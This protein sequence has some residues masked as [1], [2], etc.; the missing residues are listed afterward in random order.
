MRAGRERSLEREW[1]SEPR[2]RWG[3]EWMAET[4]SFG[5]RTYACW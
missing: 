3:G 4:A 1:R 5:P 2:S